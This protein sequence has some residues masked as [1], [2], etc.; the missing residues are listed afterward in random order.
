MDTESLLRSL[1]VFG[2]RL[3]QLSK[4]QDD[5]D[6][7]S[8]PGWQL[9][10]LVAH[11]GTVYGAVS[12]VINAGSLE[13]PT[14]AFPSPPEKNVHNWAFGNYKGVLETLKLKNPNMPVWTWGR[15]QNVAWFVRRMTHET[16]LHMWDTET[17][18]SDYSVIDGEIACDGINEYID[19]ALQFSANPKK[20]FEYPKG[21]IHL[22]RTDGLGEWLLENG[23]DGLIVRREHA[24]GDVAVRGDAMSL[25]LF[26]WG[27]NAGQLEIFGDEKTAG[28]W[29]ALAP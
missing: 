24:K 5:K 15:D 11:V 28:E 20:I 6:I 9:K 14:S 12:A 25:L 27:R 19:G 3:F 7:E 8:C 10:N 18:V 1:E 23:E 21:S 13:R 29:S 2:D 17:A 16:L 26:L 22:H 4:D